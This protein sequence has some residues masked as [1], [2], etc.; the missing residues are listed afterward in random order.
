MTAGNL[1]RRTFLKGVGL[2][3]AG[4]PAAW[5]LGAASPATPKARPNI[6]WIYVED[7]NDWLGCYGEKLIR[8]PHL[9]ALAARGVRFDR[10]FMP[11]A[12]CSATRSAI[13]TGTMQ[14][15][16]GL[17][18]HRSSRASFRRQ[19]MG[20]GHDAIRLPEGVRT[21]PELFRAAGYYT[22]NEGKEDY[23]F[24]W[25]VEDLYDRKGKRMGFQGAADGSEW[26]GRKPNQPFFGQIQLRGGKSNPKK[27][28]VE[29]SKVIVPPYYPDHPLVREEVA[30]H[31]DCIAQTDGEVG[32]IV[33]KLK[34]DG[35]L[36]S[37]VVFFFTDHGFKMLRHKQ[38]LY[39]G[40]IKVPLIAAGP[41]ALAGMLKPGSVRKD[42][43]SGI[44]IGVTSLALAGI[45]VPE[46]MEGR[47]VLAPGYKPRRYVISARDRCDYTIERIR[48][49]RTE[50]Y[51]YL[52][53]F[54]TDRPFMQPQYRDGWPVTKLL[55]QMAA[56][57][58]LDNAQ[59]QF[60]GP[61]KPPEELYDLAADPHEIHNL[62]GDPASAKV[63]QRHR[64]ILQR[65]IEQTHDK[66]QQPE[67]D[68]G[69]RAVL[70]RWGKS[71]VNPEYDR[72]RGK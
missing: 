64:D 24:V 18:N 17:H 21:I 70:K 11:A 16:L 32:Q 62:A 46:H 59:M 22:F 51:K 61:A 1:G 41:P 67:S 43:V 52:R 8:T 68:A 38:F 53:N 27:K 57:G 12:V 45:D 60:F 50:R 37:T 54:L 66:G 9:D 72:V 42:L 23:N 7:M 48:A 10:A 29:P 19:S 13:I 26:S 15:T 5:L 34:A 58:K 28:L 65:W 30:H 44:D 69:L 6:L 31:Y 71:C 2:G 25:N 49:V 39:E 63:L 55:R 33:A 47:D 56:E 35:L 20:E 3:A 4:M 14:T 40:G 36:D